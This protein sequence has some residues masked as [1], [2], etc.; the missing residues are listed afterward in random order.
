MQPDEPDD[1]DPPVER[2]TKNEYQ[3]LDDVIPIVNFMS[4]DSSDVWDDGRTHPF[5]RPDF[6]R[7]RFFMM[8]LLTTKRN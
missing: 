8:R 7:T 2:P 1:C 3:D 4:D 6:D 5:E